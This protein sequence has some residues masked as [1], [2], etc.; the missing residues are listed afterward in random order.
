MQLLREVGPDTAASHDGDDLSLET[1][2]AP[3]LICRR[4]YSA[5]YPVGGDGRRISRLSSQP[6]D[7]PGLQVHVVHVL[8]ARAHIFGR[9]VAASEALDKTTVSTENLLTVF[10]LVVA[11]YDG[12]AAAKMKP[13]DSILV[14]H[15]ARESERISD[16]LLVGG[17]VPESRPT[18]SW[19]E[20]RAVNRENSPVANRRIAAHHNFFVSH[21]C[22]RIEQLH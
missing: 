17:V 2:G 10:G 13:R 21:L 8:C 5:K 18:K 12:L 20:L 14:C 7:V 15:P 3:L 11:D 1:I 22:Q 19:S 4:L 16:R 6:C 9:Y